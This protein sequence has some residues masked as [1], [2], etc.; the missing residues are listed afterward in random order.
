MK[1]MFIL[2]VLLLSFFLFPS[3][4]NVSNDFN[5]DLALTDTSDSGSDNESS[6]G[7]DAGDTGD[8]SGYYSDTGNESDKGDVGNTGNTGNT[9]DYGDTDMSNGN[10]ETGDDENWEEENVVGDLVEN[11]FIETS[12][13]DTSTFSVDVD[14]ASYSLVR[15]YLMSYNVMPPVNNIRIEELVNYFDYNYP[16]PEEGKPFSVTMEM[17]DSPWRDDANIIMFGLKGREIDP[18]MVPASNLVFLIDTSGSMSGS[19]RL[20]LLKKAFK[21]L[22]ERVSAKDSISIVTYAGDAG[23]LLDSVPGDEKDKINKAIDSLKASGSTAGSKGIQTAYSL[24]EK[25]YNKESNNRVILATDGDFNVGPSSDEELVSIIEEERNKGIFLTILG[26]GMGNYQDEKMKKL[27]SAGNGNYFYIDT[28]KEAE[29]V[30]VFDLM[31]NMFTIAKDVKLQVVFNPA[32]I[33]KYRLIGYEHRVMP[34]KDFDDDTKDAGEIGSGHRVTAFYEV[35]LAK[36]EVSTEEGESEFGEDDYILLR[37]RYKEPD[38][39]NSKYMDTLMTGESISGV[40]SENMGFASSVVEFGMLLRNSKFKEN[41]SYDAV[42]NRAMA[43]IGDDLFGYRGEF[44]EI[45]EKAKKLD[46]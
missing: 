21:K 44:L 40:M 43:N 39:D 17:A 11:E 46:K 3:C 18:E 32:K 4:G 10:T 34:N 27:S 28:E 37:M 20:P 38:E 8:E 7:G 29:K 42:I 9:G 2:M 14:T 24:A 15:N 19:N 41:S 16:Q 35:I 33:F 25:N 13:E 12:K 1:K 30:F 6:G 22:V 26:F 5:K 31:G 23:V 36:E 45:V